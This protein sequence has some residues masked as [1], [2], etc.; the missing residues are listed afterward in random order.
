[1]STIREG[2]E[3]T[4]FS[5]GWMCRRTIRGSCGSAPRADAS[6]T[7]SAG[8]VG[9]GDEV[10]ADPT[11]RRADHILKRNIVIPKTR[12]CRIKYGLSRGAVGCANCDLPRKAT[13]PPKS[14]V[15]RIGGP[16]RGKHDYEI[17][18]I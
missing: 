18:P 17:Q 15:Q 12:E 10:C 6:C 7:D 9:E 8:L 3:D 1:M 4:F 14:R 5:S 2:N 11:G 13:Q 16:Y